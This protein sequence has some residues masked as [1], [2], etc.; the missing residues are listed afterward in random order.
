[1]FHRCHRVSNA[2]HI[3]DFVNPVTGSVDD[4][5][6]S[7]IAMFAVHDELTVGFAAAGEL[8]C[9]A[10]QLY[11]NNNATR[12]EIFSAF[13]IVRLVFQFVNYLLH[14]G[15]RHPMRNRP[16]SNRSSASPIRSYLG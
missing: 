2:E 1:M 11:K 16:K 13:G 15:F 14:R 5:L 12:A 4:F 7:D 3:A 8:Y 10:L 9:W 6:A